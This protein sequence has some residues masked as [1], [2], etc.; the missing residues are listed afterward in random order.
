MN[1]LYEALKEVCETC[2]LSDRE[3][4]IVLRQLY[5]DMDKR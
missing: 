2:V 3:V 5:N 1:D 4:L